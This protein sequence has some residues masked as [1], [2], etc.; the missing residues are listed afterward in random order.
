MNSKLRSL[1][2]A[3]LFLFDHEPQ[4]LI[5]CEVAPHPFKEDEEAVFHAQNGHQVHEQPENPSNETLE[6]DIR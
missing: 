6:T 3:G 2:I 1:A 4:T 5:E